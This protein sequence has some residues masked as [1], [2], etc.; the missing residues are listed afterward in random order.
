MI[1]CI[2][3]G[4]RGKNVIRNSHDIGVLSVSD[5]LPTL[6]LE[7]QQTSAARA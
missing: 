6:D 5:L 3:A 1:A 2:G 4:Y 7:S